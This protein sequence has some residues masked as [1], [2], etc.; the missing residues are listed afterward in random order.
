MTCQ[1]AFLCLLGHITW[2]HPLSSLA[3]DDFPPDL[4]V[5]V[6]SLFFHIYYF[7]EIIEVPSP[8]CYFGS[9]F[10]LQIFIFLLRHQ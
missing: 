1:K 6:I 3:R 2:M 9:G 10:S 8:G 7:N 4:H 5:L